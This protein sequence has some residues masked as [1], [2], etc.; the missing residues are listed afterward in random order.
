MYASQELQ[1]LLL[2]L[3]VSRLRTIFNKR[4]PEAGVL[5]FSD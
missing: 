5:D 4:I 2:G 1:V 3:E